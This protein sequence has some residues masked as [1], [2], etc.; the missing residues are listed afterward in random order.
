MQPVMGAMQKPKE[1]VYPGGQAVQRPFSC[2]GER[3]SGQAGWE[4][5]RMA[6]RKMEKWMFMR[7]YNSTTSL[8]TFPNSIYKSFNTPQ[9]E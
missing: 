2:V 9:P 3:Q 8:R 4:R 1:R 5:A 7:L 6:M